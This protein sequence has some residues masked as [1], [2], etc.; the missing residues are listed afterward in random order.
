MDRGRY[1]GIACP[2]SVT[3]PD[4]RAQLLHHLPECDTPV[5]YGW[6]CWTLVIL[7]ERSGSWTYV[8]DQ[9]RVSTA[10]TPSR[11]A[12]HQ[13]RNLCQS[14][15]TPIVGVLDRA[16]DVTWLWCQLSALPLKGTLVCLKLNRCLYRAAP[17]VFGRAKGSTQRRGYVATQ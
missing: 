5:T 2:T 15:S 4:R 1:D 14:C 11:V 3:A 12:L 6:Q 9:Q 10:S 8:R 16:Y 13:L 7:P 17:R